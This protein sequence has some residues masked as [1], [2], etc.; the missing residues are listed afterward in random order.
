MKEIYENQLQIRDLLAALYKK[1]K[2]RLRH[3]KFS[4]TAEI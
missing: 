4:F 1:D 3:L 2:K